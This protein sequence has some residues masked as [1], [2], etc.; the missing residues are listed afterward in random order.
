M[1]SLSPLR[2]Q[3]ITE[4]IT[5]SNV[6][7]NVLDMATRKVSR[8]PIQPGETTIDRAT[9]FIEGGAKKLR[10]TIKHLDG[11]TER[12]T[13]QAPK[14][15]S[16]GAL[17]RMARQM[18]EEKL[19]T[20]SKTGWKAGSPLST[21]IEEMTIPAIERNTRLQPTSKKRY[22]LAASHLVRELKGYTIRD[23]AT[24]DVL[25]KTLLKIA[26][27]HGRG[28]AISAR[29]VL[30]RYILPRLVASG[31]ITAHPLAGVTIDIPH[32]KGFQPK[33]QH[34]HTLT[35][36]EWDKVV[37][38]LL[39]RNTT[40][41]LDPDA[42]NV[43]KVTI[44]K[45]ERLVTLTLVQAVT[46]LRISESLA[47]QWEDLVTDENGDTFIDLPPEKAKGKRKGRVI[48]IIVDGVT[49]YLEQF[50]GDP[51]DYIIGSPTTREKRWD[52][53]NADDDLGVLYTQIAEA[54]GVKTLKRMTSHDWR[55]TLNGIWAPVIG[56]DVAAS[57]FGHSEVMNKEYYTDTK[58][59]MTRM[60]FAKASLDAL[61]EVD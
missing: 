52:S 13:K 31:Y 39:T 47:L 17:R 22:T 21:Y 33:S 45:H 36:D 49:D 3:Y 14:G 11:R 37:R 1:F 55:A 59:V 58:N 43:K 8:A 32:K 10:F 16:T 50:R 61:K 9:P 35:R 4:N 34:L 56:V 7:C 2:N 38:H 40:G 18:A 60:A 46:G 54:T 24:Y 51:V 25:E 27:D 44:C 57:I 12:V 48:P 29:T 20:N 42:R 30:S 19:A 6:F 28:S 5:E 15:T 23:G 41:P 53:T 26:K